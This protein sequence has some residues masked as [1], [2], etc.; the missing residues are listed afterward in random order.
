MFLFS[1]FGFLS[2]LRGV[3]WFPKSGIVPAHF[4]LS[5]V[6]SLIYVILIFIF[7]GT[8][9]YTEAWTDSIMD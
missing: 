1:L 8:A 2:P 6:G 7:K 3:D 5:G 9:H 4:T